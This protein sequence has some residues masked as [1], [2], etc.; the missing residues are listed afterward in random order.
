MNFCPEFLP[1][2]RPSPS[3]LRR[4]AR[5]NDLRCRP[6]AQQSS[7]PTSDTPS[8]ALRVEGEKSS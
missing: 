7:A 6:Q 3:R 5:G 4:G 1:S 2:L 8:L